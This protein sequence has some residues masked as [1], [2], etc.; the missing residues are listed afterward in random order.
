MYFQSTRDKNAIKY[1]SA[2]VIKQ[3]LADDG[4]LFVPT[5]IPTLTKEEIISFASL[6]YPEL[7]AT[8]LSKFLTDYS[9]DELLIDCKNAYSKDSFPNGTCPLKKIDGNT[10]SLELWHGPTCAFKDMALQI[11]PKLLS[12]S[13]VKTGEQRTALVLV[14][15]SGDTGKAAL[16]GYKDVTQIKI[17]VFYPNNGVSKIQEL[18]MAT[19]NGNNVNVCA[20][21]G[22]FDDIQTGVKQIFNNLEISNELNEKGYFLSSANSINFGRLAPQIVYYVKAYCD[23]FSQNEIE[24]GEKI[25]VC[26][27]TG[28]FG[29]ILAAYI[30]KLMGLPINKLIC[31]SNS[32]NIL[33]DF[34]NVGK[35]DRNREFYLTMSPSMDILISSNLER[36][37]YLMSNAEETAKYMKDLND[38]GCYSVSSEIKSKIDDNF[39]GYF[40]D[41]KQTVATINKYYNEYSYLM[42]THTA[43]AFSALESYRNEHGDTAKTVIAST[44]SPYKFANNV[45]GSIFGENCFNDLEVLNELS[46]ATSTAVPPP[47]FE[48][49]KKQIKFKGICASNEM[50]NE[51]LKFLQK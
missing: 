41:E 37:I 24:F 20:V 7:A 12:R 42:D 27:P 15:T 16:E 19:Q 35:Y 13:L 1:T 8:V 30:A 39:V 2:E 10:Y 28:N 40:T 36:L 22:N 38:E 34:L 6:S 46:K 29:N 44:A 47:L 11:M 33:T 14:A 51:V 32:N 45:Y 4:G 31:A 23:L 26:V 5:E 49:D 3:G 17:C 43:V 50:Y 18:Q 25:N 21:E 48:L 9:Y